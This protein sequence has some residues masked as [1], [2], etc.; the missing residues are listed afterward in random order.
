MAVAI[1]VRLDLPEGVVTTPNV[2]MVHEGD[3]L[4]YRGA[5]TTNLQLQVKLNAGA[6]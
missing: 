4:V 5:L 1:E 6:P 2:A 3:T